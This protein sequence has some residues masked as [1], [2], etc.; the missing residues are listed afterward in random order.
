MASGDCPDRFPTTIWNELLV[1]KDPDDPEQ[2]L[3][4][5]RLI[6]GYWRPVFF[7]LRTKGMPVEQAEDLTQ[8]FFLRFIERQ[9]L[10]PVDPSRGRFR[11][12]LLTVLS[13]FVADQSP[14]RTTLQ[15]SFEQRLVPISAL[16]SDK[17][18]SFEPPDTE[19]AEEVFMRQWARAVIRNVRR[20]LKGWCE[21]NG[22][23]DWYRVFAAFNLP[24]ATDSRVTQEAVSQQLKISRDQVRYALSQTNDKFAELLRAEIAEHVDSPE[25]VGREIQ[26]L[27]ELLG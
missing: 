8:E 26:E 7:Y 9:W 5:N 1:A 13:R 27:Q 16:V 23:P 19:T 18:R 21:E 3:A 14:A 10:A 12:F 25:E 15:N 24:D 20:R 17:E 2:V 22:R 11:T 4:M 6:S